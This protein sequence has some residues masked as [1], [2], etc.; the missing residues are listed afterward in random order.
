MSSPVPQYHDQAKGIRSQTPGP[1]HVMQQAS[2]RIGPQSIS[3]VLNNAG[4]SFQDDIKAN[5]EQRKANS[6]RRKAID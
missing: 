4:R 2:S 6:E 5:D 3:F 1:R